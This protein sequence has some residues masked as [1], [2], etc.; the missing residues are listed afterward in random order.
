VIRLTEYWPIIERNTRMVWPEGVYL[1]NRV[2]WGSAALVGLLVGYWRFHF[3]A[4]SDSG[5]GK[6]TSTGEGEIR[7]TC[8][9]SRP[10]RRKRR[11]SRRA[12]WPGCCSNPAGSTC[13]KPPRTSTSS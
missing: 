10:T 8:R 12:A 9:R 5:H 3:I 6:R 7:S 13:A 2:I 4:T 1:L 11:T